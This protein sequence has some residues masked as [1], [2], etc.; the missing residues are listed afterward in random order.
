M[1]VGTK[2]LLFGVHQFL[3]HP[4]A[5]LIVWTRLYGIPRDY[6]IYIAAIVH[7]WGYWGS[8]NIDGIEGK[9]HPELG[10]KIMDRLFGPQWGDFTRYHSRSYAQMMEAHPS[11]LCLVDK[12]ASVLLPAWLYLLLANLTGEIKE[13]T[14]PYNC[15][16]LSAKTGIKIVDQRSWY[17]ALKARFDY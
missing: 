5:V 14:R 1:K 2:S 12:R 4:I 10:G 9:M 3:L 15:V 7:D 13:Y 17:R 6:R 11:R 8:P 16:I